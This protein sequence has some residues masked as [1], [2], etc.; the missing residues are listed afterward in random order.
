MMAGVRR[1]PAT[2]KTIN[3]MQEFIQL[4]PCVL[5]PHNLDALKSL[6]EK[7]MCENNAQISTGIASDVEV[8]GLSICNAQLN[9]V[10]YVIERYF[11]AK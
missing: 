4:T 7:Q 5:S 9:Q 11:S 6:L 10:V 1:N 2:Y 8:T 3:T